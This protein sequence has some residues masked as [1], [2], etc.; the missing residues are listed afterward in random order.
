MLLLSLL[1]SLLLGAYHLVVE[2]PVIRPWVV[3]VHLIPGRVRQAG[4]RRKSLT[5]GADR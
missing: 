3:G 2:L 4:S 5:E 1:L